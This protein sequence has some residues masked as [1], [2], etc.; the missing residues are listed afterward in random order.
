[1]GEAKRRKASDANYGNPIR[2]LIVSPPIDINKS[3]IY[4]KSH[5]IDRQELKA[6]LLFFDKLVWPSSRAVH[7]GSGPEEEFLEAEGILARP[8]YT[9]NGDFAQALESVCG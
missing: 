3:R 8:E 4:I 5:Q 2:G 7:F 9:Y 1:M 6:A